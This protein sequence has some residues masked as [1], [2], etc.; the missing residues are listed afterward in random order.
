MVRTPTGWLY[1]HRVVMERHLRRKLTPQE[2]V[3]R[4]NQRLADNRIENLSLSPVPKK[5]AEVRV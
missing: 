4:L 2:H 5:H 3:Y 1:E